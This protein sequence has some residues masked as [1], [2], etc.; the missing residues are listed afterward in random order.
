MSKLAFSLCTLMAVASLTACSKTQTGPTETSGAASVSSAPA[1]TAASNPM[2]QKP[3]LWSLTTKMAQLPSGMTTQICIDEALA[4]RMAQMATLSPGDKQD[5]KNTQIRQ[6]PGMVD[7]DATC[8]ANGRTFASHIHMER[9]S[10][11]AYHQTVTS[12]TDRGDITVETE[13]K[14]Q[15]VCP[16]DMKAGDVVMPGGAKMNMYAM[17]GKAQSAGAN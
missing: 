1:T 11:M 7:I 16:A 13:G 4:G 5:C 15:G 14:W 3:G 10:D 2:A 6:S 9:V 12:H 17:M 8:T